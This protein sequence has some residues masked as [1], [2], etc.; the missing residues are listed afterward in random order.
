MNSRITISTV[1]KIKQKIPHIKI[2]DMENVGEDIAFQKAVRYA[3]NS[4]K[5]VYNLRSNFK[6]SVTALIE[7]FKRLIDGLEE[8]ISLGESDLVVNRNQN[9]NSLKWVKDNIY[10]PLIRGQHQPNRL[11]TRILKKLESEEYIGLVEN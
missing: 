6:F 5:A 4:Y 2:K 3:L 10:G 8:R 7:S 11:L 9:Y 1:F